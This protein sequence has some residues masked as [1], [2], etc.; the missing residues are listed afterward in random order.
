MGATAAAEPGAAGRYETSVVAVPRSHKCM[1]SSSDDP[2]TTTSCR[3]CAITPG[4]R[5]TCVTELVMDLRFK[6][7]LR[8]RLARAMAPPLAE[9]PK[10][11]AQKAAERLAEENAGMKREA[12]EQDE[13]LKRLH[14]KIQKMEQD[15]AGLL[16]KRGTV[17]QGAAASAAARGERDAEMEKLEAAIHDQQFHI[18]AINKQLLIIKHTVHGP[19]GAARKPL[20]SIYGTDHKGAASPYGTAAP[21]PARR[22]Q[23]A[24]GRKGPDALLNDT[25]EG[26][27]REILATLKREC[28]S[29]AER[30]REARKK[31]A[32]S[33]SAKDGAEERERVLQGKTPDEIRRTLGDIKAKTTMLEAS[34]DHR[35]VTIK[36]AKEALERT[37][38]VVQRLKDEYADLQRKL[39]DLTHQKKLVELRKVRRSIGCASS[40][41]FVANNSSFPY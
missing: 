26:E 39:V 11:A 1:H 38:P 21:A 29:A 22:P 37:E 30:L 24:G 10:S 12:V 41:C 8:F 17:G 6:Q 5:F 23:S 7:C 40:A 2:L 28:N 20:S 35:A 31:A 36:N 18:D 27:V 16:R 14:A 33:T 34:E 3:Q 4:S 19:P 13:R 32:A 9:A 25:S 15:M